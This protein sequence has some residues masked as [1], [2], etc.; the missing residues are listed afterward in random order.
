MGN[1]ER[2]VLQVVDACASNLDGIGH[3]FSVGTDFFYYKGL[4][5]SLIRRKLAR[6]YDRSKRQLPW[7]N[8]SDPYAIWISEI[9][10]QQTRVAAVIPYW[11]RFLKRFPNAASLAEAPEVE[12]LT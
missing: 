11:E 7:R 4:E 6:W 5:E 1:I 2:N 8:T 12:V 9:M 3:L 10:L